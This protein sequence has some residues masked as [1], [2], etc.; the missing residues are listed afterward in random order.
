MRRE[1]QNVLLILLGGALIKL[2]VTGAFLRYVKA[3]HQIWMIGAGTVMVLLAVFAIWQ[4]M[5]QKQQHDDHDH[6]HSA[7]SAWML[8]LPVV[9]VMFVAPPA[10]GADSA[11]RA[12]ERVET[13]AKD[14]TYPP[15]PP[16]EV[17]PMTISEF[18]GRVTWD[19]ARSMRGKKVLLT[20]FIARKDGRTN[21]T[22]MVISCCAADSFPVQ[23][24]LLGSDA[25]RFADN[26]WVSV[27]GEISGQPKENQPADLTVEQIH[28]T[29]EP[30]DPYES[31]DYN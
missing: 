11:S 9:A 4:D 8:V 21:L 20:G 27:T 13:R 18:H 30:E 15:L 3:S 10:L 25:D 2:A 14:T 28:A 17:A 6:H 19:G 31:P 22:R 29:Q 16:G 12:G 24:R 1:T 23:V 26:D 5:R 7:R